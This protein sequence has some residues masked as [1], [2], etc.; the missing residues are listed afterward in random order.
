MLDTRLKGGHFIKY[1]GTLHGTQ[2]GGLAAMYASMPRDTF[3]IHQLVQAGTKE[4]GNSGDSG[5]FAGS[6]GAPGSSGTD[7]ADEGGPQPAS[8]E[9]I[10]LAG[11]LSASE[12][13]GLLPSNSEFMGSDVLPTLE[14]EKQNRLEQLEPS[15]L[16]SNQQQSAAVRLQRAATALQQVILGLTTESDDVDEGLQHHS[17]SILENTVLQ[18]KTIR[19]QLAVE[20]S[21]KD[22]ALEPFQVS[23]CAPEGMSKQRM[24]PFFETMLDRRRNRGPSKPRVPLTGES[25]TKAAAV[26]P[27]AAKFFIAK[28]TKTSMLEDAGKQQSAAQARKT[29]HAAEAVKEVRKKKLRIPMQAT[30]AIDVGADDDQENLQRNSQHLEGS[31]HADAERSPGDGRTTSSIPLKRQRVQSRWLQNYEA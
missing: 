21:P 24:R 22:L 18:I 29:A 16:G 6:G 31:H 14:Q 20:G 25:P 17:A 8:A 12:A 1:A 5:G 13:T 19:V 9:N 30:D 15:M 23:A 4:G 27:E 2:H 7:I 3:D 10:I 11:W 28:G 26:E